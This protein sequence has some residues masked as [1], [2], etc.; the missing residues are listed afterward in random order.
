MSSSLKVTALSLLISS[1]AFAANPASTQSPAQASADQTHQLYTLESGPFYSPSQVDSQSIQ[2][3]G[4]VGDAIKRAIGRV[5]R[6]ITLDRR[7]GRRGY[8]EVVACYAQ[9]DYGDLFRAYGYRPREVQN[10]AVDQC[11]NYSNYCEALGCRLER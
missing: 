4:R 7:Q 6:D 2:T 8:R 10:Y 5:F 1:A 11:Y 9:N 3:F